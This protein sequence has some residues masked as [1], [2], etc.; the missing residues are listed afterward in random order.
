MKIKFYK[1]NINY[2]IIYLKKYKFNHK[3][4]LLQNLIIAVFLILTTLVTQCRMLHLLL[5][6]FYEIIDSLIFFQL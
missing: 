3:F 4:Q 5:A 2:L 6:N 1:K